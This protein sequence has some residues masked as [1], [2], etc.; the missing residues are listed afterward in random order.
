MWKLQVESWEKGDGQ[1]IKRYKADIGNARAIVGVKIKHGGQAFQLYHC[2]DV[3]FESVRWL[4]HSRGI[5]QDCNNV[6]LRH[7]RVERD[8][9]KSNSEALATAGGGPQ[10]NTCNNLTVFNHTAVGTGDDSLGLWL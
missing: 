3:T 10:I 2:D 1:E 6:V 4:G 7:T 9:T 5:L 8:P